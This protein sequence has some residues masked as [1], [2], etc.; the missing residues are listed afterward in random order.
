MAK[1]T[2][3][4]QQ[5]NV[6]DLLTSWSNENGTIHYKYFNGELHVRVGFGEWT[7]DALCSELVYVLEEHTNRISLSD[8]AAPYT[9]PQ[10]GLRARSVPKPFKF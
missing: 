9:P 8:K 6:L 4:P 2:K 5:L 1:K 10:T 3:N 7:P